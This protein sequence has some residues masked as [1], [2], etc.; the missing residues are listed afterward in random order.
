MTAAGS[1]ATYDLIVVGAGPV[2]ENVADRA[3]AGGLSVAVVEAQLLGGE[4]SFWACVPS[5]ALLTP[6]LTLE[7]A[8]SVEG[9]KQAVNGGLD[10]AAVL[11][12]RDRFAERDDSGDQSWLESIGVD[13]YRGTGRLDGERTV[14]VELNAGGSATLTANHAVAICTGTTASIAPIDGLA[15]AKP[16]ISR[17][18]TTSHVVP[19]S[20]AVIGGGVVADRDGHRLRASRLPGDGTGPIRAARRAGAVRR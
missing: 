17:D 20:L 12:R 15:A 1:A 3:V 19:E 7:L 13:V 4:C 14:V 11:A 9:A 8:R 5:K 2:G 18:A 10:V 16:W 6:G